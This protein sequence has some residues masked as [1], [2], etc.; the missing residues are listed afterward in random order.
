MSSLLFNA[1]CCC[2]FVPPVGLGAGLRE[3][4]VL[5]AVEN[6][7][8]AP[9]VASFADILK[10]LQKHA[11]ALLALQQKR[12]LDRAARQADSGSH[13]DDLLAAGERQQQQLLLGASG[14]GA[15]DDLVRPMDADETERVARIR[16]KMSTHFVFDQDVLTVTFLRNSNK[17]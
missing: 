1:G 13:L 6:F 15:G 16:D 8:C 11:R 17:V 9:Q 2:C 7:D 12:L 14:G 4:D 10:V 5:K 3:G